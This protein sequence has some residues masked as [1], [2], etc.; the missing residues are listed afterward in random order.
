MMTK[1]DVVKTNPSRT[2]PMMPGMTTTGLCALQ[3][4]AVTHRAPARMTAVVTR[5]A[6]EPLGAF[7]MRERERRL[8]E[9]NSN[10]KKRNQSNEKKSKKK[11]EKENK[12]VKKVQ[13]PMTYLA[14]TAQMTGSPKSLF[15]QTQHNWHFCIIA[16]PTFLNL[17]FF[18][19]LS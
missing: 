12:S 1:E 17:H 18:F 14:I 4:A 10:N 8:K 13:C 9:R 7:H 16:K 3:S 6:N 15:S 2:V 11:C 19:P 5:R